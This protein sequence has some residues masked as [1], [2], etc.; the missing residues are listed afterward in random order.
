MIYRV[1]RVNDST[2]SGNVFYNDPLKAIEDFAKA[3][4]VND[5]VFSIIGDDLQAIVWSRQAEYLLYK[6]IGE[7]GWITFWDYEQIKNPNKVKR[8]L[9]KDEKYTH[10]I[11]YDLQKQ[12]LIFE[13][14]NEYK[15]I[16]ETE[17]VDEY[18][19]R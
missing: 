10:V 2:V 5:E 7:E 4:P 11:L 19:D 17:K 6:Q 9:I 16:C 3:G 8:D 1:V 13:A 14:G 15:R 18:S 12:K